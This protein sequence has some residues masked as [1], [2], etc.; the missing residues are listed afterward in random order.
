M[1]GI[2]FVELSILLA[3]HREV[4]GVQFLNK[5]DET[6]YNDFMSW[7]QL[8]PHKH[9][10]LSSQ[11]DWID[12]YAEFDCVYNVDWLPERCADCGEPTCFGSGRFVNRIGV[13]EGWGCAGCSGYECD[14]CDKPIY[15]DADITDKAE[16]GHYHPYCLPLGEHYVDPEETQCYC[17]EHEKENN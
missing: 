10:S 7:S 15:L 5:L 2:T 13:N 11:Q 17:E 9:Y 3:G 16:Q 12:E 14:A 4:N 1:S 8:E 6:T